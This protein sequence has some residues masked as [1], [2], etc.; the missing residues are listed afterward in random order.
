M[1]PAER[2]VLIALAIVAASDVLISLRA[3]SQKGWQPL[4]VV[5]VTSNS[6]NVVEGTVRRISWEDFNSRSKSLEIQAIDL[7]SCDETPEILALLER[8]GMLSILSPTDPLDAGAV[9]LNLQEI[10]G[11]VE[12]TVPRF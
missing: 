6:A 10:S 11:G 7:S 3:R 4:I 8:D 2:L 9:V 1:V 12:K 5:L